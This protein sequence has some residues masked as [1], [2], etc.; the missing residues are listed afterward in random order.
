MK[1]QTKTGR[2]RKERIKIGGKH[3]KLG[4]TISLMVN[5]YSLFSF[6]QIHAEIQEDKAFGINTHAEKI[7]LRS[8]FALR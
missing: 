8:N 3:I 7:I 1:E 2:N 6:S 5:R 4:N